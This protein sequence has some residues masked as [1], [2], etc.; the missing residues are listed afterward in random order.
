MISEPTYMIVKRIIFFEFR[1]YRNIQDKHFQ[2]TLYYWP[3]LIFFSK[4]GK[5]FKLGAR[6]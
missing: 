1:L 5:F 3:P 4:W 2:V 6:R